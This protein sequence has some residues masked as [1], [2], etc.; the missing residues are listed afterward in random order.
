MKNPYRPK[1][2]WSERLHDGFDL[3]TTGHIDYSAAY[4]RWLYRAKA[5]ALGACLHGVPSGTRALDVGSGVGWVVGE[6]SRRGMLVEGCDIA[7]LAVDRL[8]QRYP[9]ASFFQL[10]L[11]SEDIPRSE[12]TYG[13]V[14]VLDVTYHITDDTLWLAGMADIARVLKPGG[15][16]IVS[17]G[18]GS[19]DA[20][21]APHVRFRSLD[22]W[23][24]VEEAGLAIREVRPYFRWLSRPRATGGFRH[25]PDGVRGGLE[26]CLEYLA[27]REPHMRCAILSN[28]DS[29]S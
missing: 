23:R 19:S 12:S 22:T 25:L 1:S 14:S 17:D 9:E 5:R 8:E 24:Q 16:V 10:S 21:P 13:L 3:R 20:E 26:L 11:G 18:L 15:R 4:N 2:Y 29:G 7:S 27:P 28:R 6:L